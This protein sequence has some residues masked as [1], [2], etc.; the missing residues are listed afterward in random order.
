MGF[1]LYSKTAS[2]TISDFIVMID[3]SNATSQ[4]KSEWNTNDNGRGR[5]FKTDGTE[6][7]TDWVNL[8][9]SSGTGRVYIRW[10]GTYSSVISNNIK[11][12]PPRATVSQYSRTDTYGQNNVWQDSLFA[13]LLDEGVTER[14]GKGYDLTNNNATAQNPGYL[15]DATGDYIDEGGSRIAASVLQSGFTML[16]RIKPVSGGSASSAHIF[17]KLTGG[18]GYFVIFLINGQTYA[19]INVGGGGTTYFNTANNFWT[20]D[21]WTNGAF[22]LESD[23]TVSSYKSGSLDNS[24][25]MDAPSNITDTGAITI[26]NSNPHDRPFDGTI[27]RIIFLPTSV[28]TAN[29]IEEDNSQ[30]EDNST[31]WGTPTYHQS[32][33]GRSNLAMRTGI[34]I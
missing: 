17:N 33:L 5:A 14:S 1:D 31:Y 2:N 4:F 32:S 10:S 8:N 18:T 16:F 12:Y 30:V 15:F 21:T 25:S 34:Y 13:F 22:R 7:A 28:G 19:R 26:G 24:G 6:L 3:L 20:A 23:G 27:D 11:L 29:W 9:Y